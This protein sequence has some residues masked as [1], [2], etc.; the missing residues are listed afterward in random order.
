VLGATAKG[1]RARARGK[2]VRKKSLKLELEAR[3]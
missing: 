1:K 2:I 3:A